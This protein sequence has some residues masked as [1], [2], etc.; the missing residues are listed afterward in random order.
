[1]DFHHAIWNIDSFSSKTK[2]YFT[3]KIFDARELFCLMILLVIFSK[4]ILTV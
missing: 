2:K 3:D 4:Q 1:M